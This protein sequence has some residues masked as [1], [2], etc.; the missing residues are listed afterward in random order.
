MYIY[1]MKKKYG[2]IAIHTLYYDVLLKKN[3]EAHLKKCMWATFNVAG[4]LDV[5]VF[6]R[7]TF[8]RV[9]GKTSSLINDY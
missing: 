5:V 4:F 3:M 9:L 6:V 8:N 7:Q 2:Q 1:F